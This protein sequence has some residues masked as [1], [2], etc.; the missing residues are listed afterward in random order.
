MSIFMCDQFGNNGCGVSKLERFWAK[1]QL[2]SNEIV[3]LSE[4]EL[5]RAVK[6]WASF[7]KIK[8]F[9]NYVIIE[10]ESAPK[11]VLFNEKNQK[12][13]DNF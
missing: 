4:L 9:K 6:N 12:V 13:S 2:Q 3:G 1:N 5:W 11:F 8:L 10:R 7:Q